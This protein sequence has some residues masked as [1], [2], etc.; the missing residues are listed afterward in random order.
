M[1]TPSDTA[2]MEPEAPPATA[3]QADPKTAEEWRPFLGT[4]IQV[5]S[6][7]GDGYIKGCRLVDVRKD[8]AQVL[9]PGHKHPEWVPLNRCKKWLKGEAQDRATSQTHGT[10]GVGVGYNREAV[11]TSFAV[12]NVSTNKFLAAKRGTGYWWVDNLHEA[13]PYKTKDSAQTAMWDSRRK[14]P[15]WKSW[16]LEP[17]AWKD[18]KA[19]HDAQRAERDKAENATAELARSIVDK[20]TGRAQHVAP[21]FPEPAEP[22]P[23]P[24]VEAVMEAAANG[25]L[26]DPTASAPVKTDEPPKPL[27]PAAVVPRPPEQMTIPEVVST[28]QA[29]ADCFNKWAEA[30]RS[31]AKAKAALMM[32]KGILEEAET[33]LLIDM[34][35]RALGL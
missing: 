13:V 6:R 2:V 10:R 34:R 28:P 19:H 15:A 26:V 23:P 32:E 22:M 5:R 14:N 33:A 29:C 11:S 1:D 16:R 18:A 9:L 12:Y 3:A 31:V 20:A 35:R 17:V 4:S 30:R 8:G 7:R 21:P 27:Q 24:L 25:T